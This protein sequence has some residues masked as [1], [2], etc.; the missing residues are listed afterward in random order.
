ML[1]KSIVLTF[2]QI[3]LELSALGELDGGSIIE[4]E[5]VRLKNKYLK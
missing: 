3:Q 4:P 5:A 2:S 1:V